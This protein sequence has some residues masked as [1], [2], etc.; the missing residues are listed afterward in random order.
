M[1]D[2]NSQLIS[3][4]AE[5]ADACYKCS[6]ACLDEKDVQKMTQCIRLDMDCAQICQ[7]T[8][9][10]ISRGSDHTKHLMKECAEICSRCAQECAKHSNM[11][12]CKICAET[13][14]KCAEMCSERISVLN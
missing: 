7:T 4:L 11:E 12:H 2:K 13:C 8:A 5:C 14:K 3:M 6:T 10:F 9:A 1:K